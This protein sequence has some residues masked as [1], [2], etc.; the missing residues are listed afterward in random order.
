VP[1]VIRFPIVRISSCPCG[2][3]LSAD[4]SSL[5]TK[6]VVLILAQGQETLLA[7]SLSIVGIAVATLFA[8]QR[9]PEN[10]HHT[11]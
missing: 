4:M 7:L 6:L 10:A 2:Q 11:V 9:R 5:L 8:Q 3:L 1:T